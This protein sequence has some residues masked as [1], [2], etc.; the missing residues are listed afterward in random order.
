M[1]KQQIA[2]L[3]SNVKLY[4]K[5][6]GSYI[7]FAFIFAVLIPVK[8][9]SS[10]PLQSNYLFT[11]ANEVEQSAFVDSCLQSLR[12]AK[13]LSDI[14]NGK[15][16]GK[17]IWG[18]VFL[19]NPQTGEFVSNIDTLGYKTIHGEYFVGTLPDSLNNGTPPN[20]GKNVLSVFYYEEQGIEAGVDLVLHDRFHCIQPEINLSGPS[21]IASHLTQSANRIT[22]RMEWYYLHQAVVNEGITQ[23]AFIDSALFMRN[24]RRSTSPNVENDENGLEII[25]GTAQ[26]TGFHLM[27]LDDKS[28]MKEKIKGFYEEMEPLDNYDRTH[29]YLTGLFYCHLIHELSGSDWYKDIKYE[30]DLGSVLEQKLSKVKPKNIT[31]ESIRNTS[32]YQQIEEEEKAKE[33][34]QNLKIK[35]IK[36]QFQNMPHLK[37]PYAGQNAQFF[38]S[39]SDLV[40]IDSLGV[41]SPFFKITAAWGVLHVNKGGMLI[42]NFESIIVTTLNLQQDE[43]TFNSDSTWRLELSSG[44]HILEEEDNNYELKQK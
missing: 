22:I 40:T 19:I 44:W 10:S 29:G 1:K 26:F 42:N 41:Y 20:L 7:I 23:S 4:F 5:T 43:N 24:Y 25:E 8:K 32:K 31:I 9:G 38:F 33:Q 14:D 3:K 13:Q 6:I 16:W 37:L 12:K 30:A 35:N 18:T 28:R 11:V 39:P 2:V 17:S 21:S 36:E 27:S 15:L 34:Q